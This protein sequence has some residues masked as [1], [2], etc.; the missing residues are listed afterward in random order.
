M[1][2]TTIMDEFGRFVSEKWTADQKRIATGIGPTMEAS[3]WAL[4]RALDA[5]I[6]RRE[7][8]DSEWQQISAV[9]ND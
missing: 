7:V 8:T 5:G 3:R 9:L 2:I 6:F 1:S 4:E